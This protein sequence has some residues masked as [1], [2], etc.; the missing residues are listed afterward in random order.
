MSTKQSDKDQGNTAGT[1]KSI[2]KRGLRRT[3][4]LWFLALSLIPVTAVSI[5]SYWNARESLRK[6]AQMS[7]RS[8]LA[9][10]TEYIRSYFSRMLTDLGHESQEEGNVEFLEDLG[11]AFG[12]SGKPLGDFI[13]SF[14]WVTIVDERGADLKHF[15]RIYGYHDVFLIDEQGNILF[16]VA[17]EDDLGTNLFEGKYS[18]TL[19]AKACRKALETG[20]PT[21]SDFEFYGPSNNAVA[22]FLV[23]VLVSEDGD[24]T[25]LM[26][27]QIQTNQIDP[28]MQQGAGLGKTE[29]TYLVGADL[30]MRS[31]SVLAGKE[32]ILREPV[33][34]EQTLLWQREHPE[35]EGASNIIRESEF[36]YD[37][38]HGKRVLGMHTN[39]LIGGVHLA[40][41]AE[42]EE[43]EAFGP[44]NRLRSIV[45]ILLIAT[46]LLVLLVVTPVSKRIVRPIMEL[47]GGAKLVAAGRFDHEIRVQ[48][49]NEIGELSQSFNNM[50]HNLRQKTEENELQNWFKTGQA[51][52]NDRMRGEQDLA[53]LGR[54]IVTCLADYLKAQI[55]AIYLAGDNN[56]LKLV[57]SY[58]FKKRKSLSNE[59]EFGEGLVGQAALEKE[60]I[61]LTKVPSDYIA[62]SSGLGEA[63]PHNILVKPFLHNGEVKGVLEL[64][65]LHE[66]SDMNLDFLNQVA[67][68]IAVAVHSAQ[69]RQK[70]QEL[71]EQTQEQAEELQTQQEELRT[72]NEELEEQT[73]ALKESEARLQVQ[74][75]E[76]QQTNEELEEQTKLLEE[77]KQKIQQKN[78]ELEKTR[79]LI[80]EKAKDLEITGKYKSEFLANMSHELRTPLNSILLL[81]KLLSDNKDGNLTEKQVEFSQTI[82]SSGSDLLNLINDVLD[83]SKVEAGRM[84]LHIEDVNLMHF[85]EDMKRNFQHIAQEKG[86]NFSTDLAGDLPKH[87]RTDRSRVEQIVKNFFSN[88]F[89]FTSKGSVTLNISR[90]DHRVDLSK[91]GLEPK[92]AISFSVS[93]TGVGIPK[94]KQKLIFEAFQQA[95]GT[96]NRKFGGTGLG[97]SISREMAKLL[98]GEVQ[99][100]SEEGKG[101][102]FSL[103]IPERLDDSKEGPGV[104][105][106]KAFETRSTGRTEGQTGDPEG[107]SIL[108]PIGPPKDLEAIADDRRRLSP[109][110]KSIL[111]IEDDPKF[112]Q[113]MR[114]L[115]REKGFKVLIAGDGETGLHFA[116]Y[117][118]PSAIILDIGLPGIDGWTVMSRLKDNP[119]TRHIPVHFI[120]ATDE[121]VDAMK[122]GGIGFLTKPVSMEGLQE[123]F[124]K[125]EN[126]ISKSKKNLLLVEDDETQRKAIVALIGN[127][128]VRITEVSTGQEAYDRM[129]SGNF[130]CVILDLGLPDMSGIELLKRIRNNENLIHLPIVIYTGKDLTKEE[131]ITIDKYAEKIIIKGVRSA[132]K[133][134]DETTL[135]LH[136]I[137]ADLPEEKQRMLR[138]IHDKESILNGK[139]ILLVDDDMRNVYALTNIIEEK[140]VRILV[141]KTGEEGLELLNK[142]SDIALILMD[143]MMPEMDGYEAMREIRKQERFKKIPIIALTAKAMKGDRA[144]CIEAG[145][146]DYLAKPVDADKLFSMLRVWLY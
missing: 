137:E 61:L 69:S 138:M 127:G 39:I 85:A 79:T 59:F 94:D 124:E 42:I 54:N 140:G 35:H 45:L 114:D 64:G 62:V 129:S 106:E 116:D 133:L 50:L 52:L 22:G 88:S 96:T 108:E 44:A 17:G 121:P 128:D 27:L 12:K 145:A 93:D 68:N 122:M 58:A 66:F 65:T 103:F 125:V 43:G 2:F 143:I 38:P 113:V 9:V 112:A 107:P 20:Q 83:L 115:S 33:E 117:Y 146:S 120:S 104:F 34:T 55:G 72:T 28:I 81:S 97:L 111:I 98:E 75:E 49:K 141:G 32:T 7:L 51:E 53:T 123:A 5:Y 24:K 36:I 109:K 13:K 60:S 41:I 136:R 16:S 92:K 90:A 56:H 30:K 40:V 63:A 86:L 74:Q 21:F 26:A 135:F 70:V 67:E 31:T 10:K 14:T 77:Q 3:L 139:K 101:S 8:A 73:K 57:G 4:F 144:K 130:D 1:S 47:S 29:E 134:L 91:S 89:K 46:G 118:K 142:N 102:T 78:L 71:L 84:E 100:Q 15:R 37:G 82:N 80:E 76:L 99:L 105:P 18:H 132:E 131:E 11:S 23:N 110:D 19:F 6:N 119:V 48:A 25:G 95:D 87:V 126:V